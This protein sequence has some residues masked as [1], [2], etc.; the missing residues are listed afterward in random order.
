MMIVGCPQ[1]MTTVHGMPKDVETTIQKMINNFVWGGDRA[2]ITLN[3]T[4]EHLKNGGVNLPD[5]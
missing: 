1:Y 2:S 3:Q 5:I 4:R